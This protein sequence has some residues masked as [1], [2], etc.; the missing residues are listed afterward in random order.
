M[1]STHTRT[2]TRAHKLRALVVRSTHCILCDTTEDGIKRICI[3][4]RRLTDSN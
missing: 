4:Y 3:H 2:H 1:M